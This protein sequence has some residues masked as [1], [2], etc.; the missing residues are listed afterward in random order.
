MPAT[1]SET[2]VEASLNST[3]T[4]QLPQQLQRAACIAEVLRSQKS[5]TAVCSQAFSCGVDGDTERTRCKRQDLGPNMYSCGSLREWPRS[6]S[7]V[8]YNGAPVRFRGGTHRRCAIVGGS[9]SLRDRGLGGEID[10]HD[11]VVRINR[12]HNLNHPRE[13]SDLGRRTDVWFAP[14]GYVGSAKSQRINVIQH[15]HKENGSFEHA[16]SSCGWHGRCPFGAF[17]GH[18]EGSADGGVAWGKHPM[19]GSWL[20]NVSF[21]VGHQR[22]D[23]ALAIRNVRSAGLAFARE[24]TGFHAVFT[25]VPWCNETSLYGFQGNATYDGHGEGHRIG[26]EHALLRGLAQHHIHFA[27]FPSQHHDHEMT[28]RG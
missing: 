8:W 24:S 11:M 20:R 25:F 28:G 7:I 6:S 14:L 15:S 26:L 4:L 3:C 5:P 12:L 18:W 22:A 2:V 19:L 13:V 9:G 10:S 23:L 17:V 1:A 21:P 16:V 27:D